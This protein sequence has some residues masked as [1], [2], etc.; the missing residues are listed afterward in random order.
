MD[1]DLG[2][3]LHNKATR[4]AALSAEE[5]VALDQWYKRLDEEEE[6]ALSG[7][8]D[9]A[10]ALREQVITALAE[11]REVTERIQ[12]QIGENETLRREIGAMQAELAAR[13]S[14]RPA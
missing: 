11:V 10:K 1:L 5:R 6:A 4:G 12:E 14:R 7:S 9:A 13:A 2:Q 8:Q 3:Q